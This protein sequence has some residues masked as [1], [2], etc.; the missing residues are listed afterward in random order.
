LLTVKRIL[1]VIL[2][3]L[4]AAVAAGAGYIFLFTPAHRVT[5]NLKIEPTPERLAR[6]EYLV[7]HVVMCFAC[8]TKTDGTKRTLPKIA[9]EGAGGECFTEEMGFPGHVCAPN[10]TSDRTAGIGA[11]TDD[12]VL[13]AVR[14]G[15]NKDGETLF[16]MMPYGSYRHLPD[17]DAY[18][19]I[20]YIRTLPPDPTPTDPAKVNFPVN[21]FIRMAPQPVES[22]VGEASHADLVAYG[23]HMATVA[24]CRLCHLDDL[25]GGEP[26]PTV[27]GVVRSSNLTP[28]AQGIVPEQFDDF[29]RIFRA[30]EGGNLPEGVTDRDYTVMP[31]ASYA[32]MAEEDLRA[33]HAYLRSLPPVQKQIQTY[34]DAK[35]D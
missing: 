10:I 26:F 8:H 13:R 23:S 6:G 1:T 30:Y 35:S 28:G 22:P 12:E 25:A 29:L 7:N 19:I 21:M 17:E 20:V 24:G 2:L 11:W 31:W 5:T 16:P 32:G 34:G 9:P 4:L 18:A 15:V 27:Q 14:E 33:I 3:L